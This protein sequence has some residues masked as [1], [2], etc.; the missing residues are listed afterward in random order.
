MEWINVKV[1]DFHKLWELFL[2]KYF[3]SW[4]IFYSCQMS[5]HLRIETSVMMSLHALL[6]YNICNNFR[7]FWKIVS[8]FTSYSIFK[9]RS[10]FYRPTNQVRQR[11]QL[12]CVMRHSIRWYSTI[13]WSKYM[14][15]NSCQDYRY[16]IMKMAFVSDRTLCFR[17]FP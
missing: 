2:M 6:H 4:Y 16:E 1:S 13:I 10:N 9:V 8:N 11:F 5:R 3:P 12:I 14:V 17:A 7:A 15:S